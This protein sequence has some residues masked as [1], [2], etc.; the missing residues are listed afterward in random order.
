ML[1]KYSSRLV[2]LIYAGHHRIEMK[3]IVYSYIWQFWQFFDTLEAFISM[4]D[5]L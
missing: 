2:A 3:K 1:K 5:G 4:I